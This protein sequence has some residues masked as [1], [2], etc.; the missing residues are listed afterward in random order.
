MEDKLFDE[1]RDLIADD[2]NF[3]ITELLMRSPRHLLICGWSNKN[4]DNESIERDLE[5]YA[6]IKHK[7]G[8]VFWHEWSNNNNFYCF[9]F[10]LDD[11]RIID[12]IHPII[13]YFHTLLDRYINVA[14]IHEKE[15]NMSIYY[16][17]GFS[18]RQKRKIKELINK[19]STFK[20]DINVTESFFPINHL[21][22]N[23]YLW[24]GI[25]KSEQSESIN[26]DIVEKIYCSIN[27]SLS[28]LKIDHLNN[29]F[30]SIFYNPKQ[31]FPLPIILKSLYDMPKY[32]DLRNINEWYWGAD[33][34]D[35][36]K[37]KQDDYI[38]KYLPKNK[39]IPLAYYTRQNEMG[40][41]GPHIVLCPSKIE[42]TA[43]YLN[44]SPEIIYLAVLVHEL[45]HAMMDKKHVG[46]TMKSLFAHA[47]EESL[48]NMVVLQWFEKYDNKH[49]K[50][51]V[52]FISEQPPIYKFGIKQYK[53]NVAWKKWGDSYKNMHFL[54]KE[55]FDIWTSK[56]IRPATTKDIFDDVF[57]MDIDEL[58]KCFKNTINKNKLTD[59][60]T[61]SYISYIKNI[62]ERNE[63]E[64]SIWLVGVIKRCKESDDPL[65]IVMDKVK[66]ING[67]DGKVI[68]GF[69]KFV[70]CIL[71]F[72]FANTWLQIDK[73]DSL[74]CAL[75]A[76]NALFA[77][78]EVVEAVKKGELGGPENIKKK[79]NRYASWDYMA[80]ARNTNMIRNKRK[81][82]KDPDPSKTAPYQLGDIIS[83]DN[84]IANQAIK[85]AVI[86]SYKRN[87]NCIMTDFS[88]LRDYEACHIWDLPGDRR[89]YASIA[90]LILLP[91]ALAKLTDHND[92]V[93]K[94]LRYEVFKRF[95]FKP[96]E[97]TDD[98]EKPKYYNNYV[99]RS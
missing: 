22:V 13:K 26:E 27:K 37:K 71:G 49:L 52:K 6:L 59:G 30:S 40:C 69:K 14:L 58:I 85:K 80:H 32:E 28:F 81:A 16:Q 45:A 76:K 31:S 23:R 43:S 34:D 93:K 65:D 64:T 21:I 5:P 10:S 7:E 92:E 62:D 53:A 83:D 1:I 54:L 57:T 41:Y 61:N 74:F 3:G 48:A 9:E 56:N 91:R 73:D 77:S 89:Y 90:N 63:H 35:Y 97:Q 47:M 12:N 88:F 68:S 51:V 2:D 79:G 44:I 66:K 50:Q 8:D 98:P 95:G 75:V 17:T 94:L 60:S 96:D 18:A 36:N 33:E 72:Y 15:G 20:D 11:K 39:D 67:L 82:Y 24:P 99:W 70:Q 78:K 84:T 42:E 38:N 29:L 4:I 55:W 46:K 19:I 87:Y 86:E 25:E